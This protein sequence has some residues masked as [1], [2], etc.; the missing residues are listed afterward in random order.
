MVET[1]IATWT[2]AAIA[3]I[4]PL[5]AC[6]ARVGH[7]VD[8]EPPSL[9]SAPCLPLE[10][11]KLLRAAQAGSQPDADQRNSNISSASAAR[12]RPLC[13]PEPTLASDPVGIRRRIDAGLD[14]H[15]QQRI[16]GAHV[17]SAY[18]AAQFYGTKL[19]AAKDLTTRL[20]NDDRDEDRGGPSGFEDKAARAPAG[21]RPRWR[22]NPTRCAPRPRAPFSLMPKSPARPGR[23][24]KR[25]HLHPPAS[26]AAAPRSRSPHSRLPNRSRRRGRKAPPVFVFFP[27]IFY[28]G[29]SA[30][31]R[32]LVI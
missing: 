5:H 19:S 31:A 17:A 15:R 8:A 11:S 12:L 26:A 23:L 20:G 10:S 1:A 14:R 16:V 29:R 4:L 2:T 6:P 30:T 3:G 9:R 18:G 21:S 24:T 7:G 32:R 28:C 13:P 22:C 25:P 27:T